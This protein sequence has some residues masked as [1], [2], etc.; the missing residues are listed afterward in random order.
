MKKFTRVICIIGC[1]LI[2]VWVV[3]F[4]KLDK[5][6][7]KRKVIFRDVDTVITDLRVNADTALDKA[8]QNNTYQLEWSNAGKIRF[9]QLGSIKGVNG[10]QCLCQSL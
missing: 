8:I 1:I 10:Q 6:L 5:T 7:R 3:I 2:I 4:P 9:N